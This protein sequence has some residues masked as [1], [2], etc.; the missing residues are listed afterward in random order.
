MFY[1]WLRLISSR[2]EVKNVTIFYSV[3]AKS[4]VEYFL[5]Q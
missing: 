5:F 4:Y 1:D 2:L 3:E